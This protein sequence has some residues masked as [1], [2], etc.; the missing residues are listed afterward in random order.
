MG[1]HADRYQIYKADTLLKPW[2]YDESI[3]ALRWIGMYSTPALILSAH[4][5]SNSAE[6]Y[7]RLAGA[8]S[9][10]KP[11]TASKGTDRQITVI[12]VRA[13]GEVDFTDENHTC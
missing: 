3:H 5:K 11:Q 8:M 12:L 7:S 10:G 2:P 1:A 4:R 13:T 6:V 9:L